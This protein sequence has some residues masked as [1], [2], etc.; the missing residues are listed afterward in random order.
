M[1]C[2]RCLDARLYKKGDDEDDLGGKRS[3][4]VMFL[5]CALGGT[6]ALLNSAGLQSGSTRSWPS[7]GLSVAFVGINLTGISTM[8]HWKELTVAVIVGTLIPTGCVLL[9]SDWFTSGILDMW[10]LVVLVMDGLLAFGAPSGAARVMLGLTVAYLVFRSMQEGFD[11]GFWVWDRVQ[12]SERY[13][14]YRCPQKERTLAVSGLMFRLAAFTL[15]YYIT[16]GFAST[17]RSQLGIIKSSVRVAERVASLLAHYATDEALRVVEKEG[18]VLPPPLLASFSQLLANLDSYRVYLPDSILHPDARCGDHDAEGLMR[19]VAPPGEA[20]ECAVCFTDIQSSTALWELY[21]QGMYEGLQLHNQVMRSLA[22]QLEGYEVKTI[23]DAFMLTFDSPLDACRFGLEAQLRLLRQEWPADLC[24]SDLC[25]KYGSTPSGG[26]LWHG[27][28]VRVGVH[29]GPVRR[30]V[31]PV[32]GRAD[33]F[34][35]TVNTAARVE[36]A[37]QRGGLLGVT[38]AVLSA[39]AA[40]GWQQLGN[41]VVSDFGVRELR[42]VHDPVQ[43]HL[44]LPRDLAARADSSTPGARASLTRLA[45]LRCDSPGARAW[46][47]LGDIGVTTSVVHEISS[48]APSCSQ[49]DGTMVVPDLQRR[50]SPM[51]L[52]N[53]GRFPRD[54]GYTSDPSEMQWASCRESVHSIGSVASA[55][56]PRASAAPTKNLALV[57]RRSVATCAV[58]RAALQGAPLVARRLPLL[59]AAIESAADSSQGVLT[60]VLSAGSVVTWNAAV[61]C[62][63]HTASCVMLLKAVVR[64]VSARLPCHVGV[65]TGGVLS[66]NLAAGRRRFATVVGGCIELATALSGEAELCGDAALLTGQVADICARRMNASRA[67]LW[68]PPSGTPILVWE[69]AAAAVQRAADSEDDRWDVVLAE[70]PQQELAQVAVGEDMIADWPDPD[71]NLFRRAAEASNA[72][73]G[74]RQVLAEHFR[75]TADEAQLQ[76]CLP[77]LRRAERGALCKR[78]IPPVWEPTED[79]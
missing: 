25:S 44:V 69:V 70:V 50:M 1:S 55:R 49:P 54:S 22:A 2:L 38:D 23:G 10:T 79:D 15:D 33:Y 36:S 20:G 30:E 59:V 45:E 28:R 26:P 12:G 72:E 75:S 5:G 43:I 16:R 51:E 31:N 4:F 58:V 64:E 68:C 35:P 77:M 61:P 9:V 39:V 78:N 60:E 3:A 6:V 24:Q 27:L 19:G 46:P 48:A 62:A 73:G 34:G 65:A 71:A 67:Q 21:P 13:S 42:G 32:T 56:Q 66:G 74:A 37:L 52:S 14:M 7:I 8:L 53:P 41:P 18:S 57:L 40:D 47:D 63:I 17:M 29:Y 11:Y 76:R